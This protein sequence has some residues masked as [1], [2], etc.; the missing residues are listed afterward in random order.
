MA[1][2]SNPP[3]AGDMYKM[4]R[5]LSLVAYLMSRNGRRVSAEAIRRNVEIYCDYQ[6]WDSFIRR[7]YADRDELSWMGIDILHE[8]DE[9][10]EGEVYRLP[11]G[12]YFLPP[13][14]FSRTEL[15]ALNTCFHLLDG[16]FAYSR[17]LRLALQALALGTGNPLEDPVAGGF[18]VDL[19]SS[20]FDESVAARQ[21]EI[22]K[23]ISRR[24]TI[25]FDYYAASS[26]CVEQRVLD[27]YD[28]MFTRGSWY[29]VG[30]ARER[31][32][33]RI[34]KL[35]RI[36]G[37]IS[38]YSRKE[39]D[40][41]RPDDFRIGDYLNLEPWQLGQAQDTAEVHF[42]PR[43]GW[44]AKKNLKACGEIVL[45][46]EG[47][48]TLTT[49]Y[50]DAGPL[51]SLV[52]GM[53]DDARL[54]G[55][56]AARDRLARMLLR[57]EE[58]HR[59]EPPPDLAAAA[60][61]AER[62]AAKAKESRKGDGAEA[63]S[64]PGRSRRR[65]TGR[66]GP[67]VPPER[68]SQMAKTIA[69]LIDRLGQKEKVILPV[70][71]VIADL[72]FSSRKE[73][74]QAMDLLRLVNTG[75]GDYL[76]EAYVR[77]DELLVKSWPEGETLKRP[78]HLSPREARAMLLAIDL[79]GGQILAGH[80]E[81]LSAARQKIL[82]AAGNFEECEAIAVGDTEKEDFHI[83]RVINRGLTEHRLVRI[84]YLSAGDSEPVARRVEP[85]LVNRTKGQ[86]YLVAWCRERDAI[87]TFRFEMI[88]SARLLDR[89]FR[90]RHPESIDLGAFTADPRHPSGRQA[91]NMATIW[92]AP[93][94]ARWV[95]E[96][97]EGFTVLDDNAL[98]GNIPYFSNHWMV[99]EILKYGGD[100][101][102]L[103]PAGLRVEIASAAARLAR[104]YI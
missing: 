32:S 98:I 40:F 55:P 62:D 51:C 60:K 47:S 7:F 85:Y 83:C 35:Q 4:I 16:Q 52:L 61:K 19:L 84:E 20:G 97:E 63:G 13:V 48:A 45:G 90:P 104:N 78:V 43:M 95:R 77:G 22:E 88:K 54:S 49:A 41:D 6:N 26:D 42:S 8:Q 57:I 5:Q 59:D 50:S 33:I 76:V 44:W 101:V 96:R 102:L 79:V 93:G 15:A 71:E 30:Y 53:G 3:P 25:R 89:P 100:A 99:K 1:A 64:P 86:T 72:G 58:T 28:M 37:R 10:G 21:K 74:G 12:N 67:Q 66:D 65:T 14:K 73:L 36:Q 9:F 38:M 92:F 39:H 69:Y 34:F 82:E 17:V 94:P 11:P 56:P 80:F 87:R 24:K 29:L 68:F 103:S 81:S 91:P 27:P 75:A 18:S 31:G 2:H 23:A 70:A 46:E